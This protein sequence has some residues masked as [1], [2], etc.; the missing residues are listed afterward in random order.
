MKSKLTCFG[1]IV[2]GVILIGIPTVYALEFLPVTPCRFIDTRNAGGAFY[3]GETRVVYSYGTAAKIGTEQGVNPDGCGNV[4]WGVAKAVLINIVAVD[5]IGQGWLTVWPYGVAKPLAGGLNYGP[6]SGDPISNAF[7]IGADT[8]YS[9]I[10][11]YAH[12]Q[13]H[14]VGDIM[15]IYYEP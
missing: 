7:S 6:K 10:N 4:Y 15:G 14:V 11:I 8:A 12:K 5:A 1:I 2:L 9:K 13:T 3:S